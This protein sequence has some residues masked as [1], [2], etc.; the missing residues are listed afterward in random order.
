MGAKIAFLNDGTLL[1]TSGDG[2]DHREKA[3]RLDNHFGKIIRIIEMARFPK[4]IHLYQI[5]MLYQ[6][7][8]PMVIEICKV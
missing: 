5:Q 4:I 2:Y 3:Q 1:L 6:T 8:I 7:Y